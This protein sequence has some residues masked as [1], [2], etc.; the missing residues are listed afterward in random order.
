MN[1][2]VV[3]YIIIGLLAVLLAL[4]I[5]IFVGNRNANTNTNNGG[6]TPPT[7]EDNRDDGSIY[8]PDLGTVEDNENYTDNKIYYL[9]PNNI[10]SENLEYF[11]NYNGL[12]ANSDTVYMPYLIG[13]FNATY[14]ADLSSSSFITIER[15]LGDAERSNLIYIK[16][17][18]FLGKYDGDDLLSVQPALVMF[19]FEQTISNEYFLR[20]A[21]CSYGDRGEVFSEFA[22]LNSPRNEITETLKMRVPY[23]LTSNYEEVVKLFSLSGLTKDGFTYKLLNN[24]NDQYYIQSNV[25]S[26]ISSLTK[27]LI[28]RHISVELG[29]GVINNI[30]LSDYFYVN[31]VDYDCVLSD[32]SYINSL[33]LFDNENVYHYFEDYSYTGFT[34]YSLYYWF[35]N[36][37]SIYNIPLVD[38]AV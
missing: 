17:S 6:Y 25:L 19:G 27:N 14:A 30:D 3:N 15:L 1:K 32:Y 28:S 21:F 22:F 38:I 12:S 26:V 35:N 36:N 10:S 34:Y 29:T 31:N 37:N 16:F 4:F 18:T 20:Y 7:I 5:G 13:M 11:I 24:E 9:K 23:L 33:F 2:K 8:N